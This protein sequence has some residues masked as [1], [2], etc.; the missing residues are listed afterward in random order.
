MNKNKYNNNK[1]E[2]LT[3]CKPLNKLLC[4]RRLPVLFIGSG[5]SKRYLLDFPSWNQLLNILRDKIGISKTSYVAKIQTI[6]NSN[7]Q[8][9]QGK[10]YQKIA[11]Y[12]E[13]TFL[14]KIE[15]DKID[16][17]K[18]FTVDEILN[19]INNQIDFF[20]MLV[21]KTVK[22]YKINPDMQYELEYF[23]KICEKVSM[24][25]T[26]NYD[27]FLQNEVCKNFKVYDSQ[28]KYYF[29]N[30][31]GYGELYKIHGSIENPNQI[32]ICEQDYNYFNQSLKLVSSKLI[33][34]LLDYPIIFLGYSLEDENIK[35]IMA[36]FVNSFDDNILQELK[37]YMIMIIYEKGQHELVASDKQFTDNV[38]NKSITL[39]TIKTDN[40]MDIYKI[41]NKLTPVATAYELR[42]YKIMIS[43]LINKC[44]KGEKTIYVQDLDGSAS[45]SKAMYIG[46][47]NEIQN[48][49]KSY[50]S[51]TNEELFIKLINK[52]K[53]NYNMIAKDWYEDKKI[54]TSQ[55]RL[56]FGVFKG[57][58]SFK[59]CS[60]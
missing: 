32:I 26:T 54:S 9:S 8:I 4:S 10:L 40:F 59:V 41:I 17:N 46:T 2:E 6:K 7:P 48:F 60:V 55:Y 37:N 14:K 43:E 35:N 13:Y 28:D 51:F 39:T 29:R 11:S 36:D 30:S 12:L 1:T 21:A 53:L 47:K 38:S 3:S 49:K 56:T 24:I 57:G 16:L 52:D 15:D 5:I 34:S 22:D 33:N 44:A 20:K 19:C 23:S 58:S 45:D 50:S 42:K 18:I 31:N 27:N 25:F